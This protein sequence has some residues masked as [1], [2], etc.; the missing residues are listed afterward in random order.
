MQTEQQKLGWGFGLGFF[1]GFVCLWFGFGF[2]DFFC[3]GLFC[4]FLSHVLRLQEQQCCQPSTL[5]RN[6]L[7]INS[8]HFK[9]CFCCLYAP[10]VAFP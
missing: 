4:G 2:C 7:K 3:G 6:A 5:Q 8:C 10:S 1:L 9:R